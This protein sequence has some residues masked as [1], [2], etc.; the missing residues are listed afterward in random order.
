MQGPFVTLQR[1][2]SRS[3]R[4]LPRQAH[5]H[6]RPLGIPTPRQVLLS[7]V[8][9]TCGVDASYL[10]VPIFNSIHAVEK[11]FNTH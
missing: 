11:P 5:Q 9:I 1:F 6:G 10:S 3:R 4:N 2:P 7:K 8:V